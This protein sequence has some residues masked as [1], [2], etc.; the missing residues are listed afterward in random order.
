MTGCP[1]PIT[2]ADLLTTLI[3]T[4]AITDKAWAL[5]FIQRKRKLDP[6]AFVLHI[7]FNIS[8]AMTGS[9]EELRRGFIKKTG[10]QIGRSA[11]KERFAKPLDD[12]LAWLLGQIQARTHRYQPALKG[13]LARFKA[14]IAFDSTTIQVSNCLASIFPGTRKAR[15]SIKI[16]TRICALSMGLR[17]HRLTAGSFADCKAVGF[18]WKDCGKLFLFDKGYQSASFWWKIHR[19]YG[20]F[21]TRLPASYKPTITRS[22]RTHRGR[23][24]VVARKKLRDE[25][26]RLKRAVIDVQCDFQVHVRGYG[27]KRGRY[28]TV[29]FRVVGLWNEHTGSYHLYVTNLPA[30][31]FDAV[32]IGNIYGLRWTV[33]TYYRAAKSGLGLDRVKRLRTAVRV[34]I[35]VKCALV[36][37]C[38]AMISRQVGRDCVPG[39][40]VNAEAWVLVWRQ[41]M[42]DWALDLLFFGIEPLVTW[43]TLAKLA[44]DPNPK[45]TS[46]AEHF[47]QGFQDPGLLHAA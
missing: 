40:R 27:G 18:S 34:R 25:I 14:V 15:A 28:E 5:R 44:V 7:I 19:V 46:L 1:E 39:L 36:R 41:E 4:D 37:S 17:W 2:P 20:Y 35:W 6:L 42:V 24:R 8:L 23:C 3:D 32:L 31:D 47:L 12:L 22:N 43:A 33:E 26:K 45:R 30:K 13:P 16:H 38:V 10:C 11:F 9:T 21:V 29:N